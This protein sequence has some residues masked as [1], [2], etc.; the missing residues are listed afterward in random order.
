M[1]L[2]HFFQ[3][4]SV[5]LF[6]S[7]SCLSLKTVS[8]VLILMSMFVCLLLLLVVFLCCSWLSLLLLLF[9]T[10]LLFF[11]VLLVNFFL[12]F[13]FLSFFLFC[14]FYYFSLSSFPFITPHPLPRLNYFL[15]TICPAFISTFF[16]TSR[17]HQETPSH[18]PPHSHQGQRQSQCRCALPGGP[19][20]PRRR[21]PKLSPCDRS[22]LTPA[23]AVACSHIAGD[24]CCFAPVAAL[25][26]S[27]LSH[28]TP[29]IRPAA[30]QESPG[31]EVGA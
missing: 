6:S 12:S 2:L 25:A 23:Q 4:I 20:C 31:M 14:L 29:S 13:C 8:F 28:A 21:R 27:R 9:L 1:C 19:P 5:L 18:T 11:P 7:G 16:L 22:F 10:G 15:F 30:C 24:P 3:D 26:K 17:F